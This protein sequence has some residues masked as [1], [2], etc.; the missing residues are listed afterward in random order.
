MLL[1]N[2]IGFWTEPKYK[3][4]WALFISL[5]ILSHLAAQSSLWSLA[6]YSNEKILSLGF[7][8]MVKFPISLDTPCVM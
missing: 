2:I 4:S 3:Y 5:F 7:L 6:Q 1:I 8:F